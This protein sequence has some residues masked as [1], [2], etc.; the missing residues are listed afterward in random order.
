M[1]WALMLESYIIETDTDVR[2]V[3]LSEIGED[4]F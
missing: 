2:T 4:S 3:L 1:A